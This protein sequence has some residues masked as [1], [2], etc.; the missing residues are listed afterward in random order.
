MT[1]TFR[2]FNASHG[3]FDRSLTNT[4][5]QTADMV[6]NTL[7]SDG[8]PVCVPDNQDN[9]TLFDQWFRDSEYSVTVSGELEL[10]MNTAN[11]TQFQN[12]TFFPLDGLGW[13]ERTDDDSGQNITHNYFFTT[14][15]Q[16]AFTYKGGE[17]FTFSGDDDVWVFINNTLAIDLGGVHS[18][19][20][21][22]VDLDTLPLTI[23]EPYTLNLFHAERQPTAS[24]FG[25]E[26]TIYEQ[27]T[28]PPTPPALPPVPP[29]GPSPPAPPP[30]P[31]AFAEAVAFDVPTTC[32]AENCEELGYFYQPTDGELCFTT[33][34]SSDAKQQCLE[35]ENCTHVLQWV[36]AN[37]DASLNYRIHAG[38]L[39]TWSQVGAHVK[40]YKRN[41]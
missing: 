33:E 7:G 23:D 1:V 13:D 21:E 2:D 11:N 36:D 39:T 34:T 32:L 40:A 6:K 15:L 16:I 37:G 5:T 29:F 22:T 27:C 8:L 9:C 20:T 10:T 38:N 4:Q 25:F 31:P 17:T 14:Q 28:S 19:L 30:S 35:C 26:T 12:D 3:S 18:K 41:D 24:T